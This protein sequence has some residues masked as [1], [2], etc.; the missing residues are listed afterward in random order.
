[1]VEVCWGQAE[2]SQAEDMSISGGVGSAGANGSNGASPN[3]Q[4]TDLKIERTA[5]YQGRVSYF[6]PVTFAGV[7]LKVTGDYL[8][9]RFKGSTDNYQGDSWGDPVPIMGPSGPYQVGIQTGDAVDSSLNVDLAILTGDLVYNFPASYGLGLVA[10]GPRVQ[11]ISYHDTMSLQVVPR[12]GVVGEQYSQTRRDSMVGLGVTASWQLGDLLPLQV[13]S[14]NLSPRLTFAASLGEGG[15]MKCQTLEVFLSISPGLGTDLLGPGFPAFSTLMPRLNL[16][17]GYAYF[18][19]EE[20][21][22]HIPDVPGVTWS[23]KA[24]YRISCPMIRAGISF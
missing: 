17:L 8:G 16:E 10:L 18:N 5:G 3:L 22:E 12:G 24:E 15:A 1:M 11:F 6:L 4:L 7:A 20:K 23:D 13:S 2:A 19:F 14:V 9:F 21:I